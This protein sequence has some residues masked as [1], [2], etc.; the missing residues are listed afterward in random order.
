MTAFRV[1]LVLAIALMAALLGTWIASD[2]G[3]VVVGFRGWEIA[4][5]VWAAITALLVLSVLVYCAMKLLNLMWLRNSKIANWFTAKRSLSSQRQTLQAIEEETNGNTIEAIRL[6]VAAGQQ[7]PNPIL[8]FLRAS[9]LASRIGAKE[10]AEE[11]RLDAAKLGDNELLVFRR[12][13]DA[14]QLIEQHDKRQGL[15]ALR[16]LLEDHPRC[17]PALLELVRH[18]HDVEDWVGAIEYLDVLSRLSFMSDEEIYEL[19]VTSWIGRIRQADPLAVGNV[20]HAVPRKLKQEPGV[21]M[22]FVDTL[23]EKGDFDKAVH[24]LGRSIN[25]HWDSRTVLAYGLVEGNSEKQLKI[26]EEWLKEHSGDAALHLTVG[27]LYRRLAKIED[28][29]SHIEK[30]VSLGGVI[31]A[32]LEL[33]ELHIESGDT[34]QASEVMARIKQDL[35]SN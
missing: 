14:L 3:Y 10:K 20:W 15:R 7:S 34:Q 23:Q 28:A 22:A 13:N 9:E 4:T 19:L 33:A 24:E 2:E 29:R 16:R 18:C 8:H 32:K 31:D 30:S 11:L 17:A 35:A 27:R 5:S 26:A 1:I 6:L 25:R 21:L 12:L